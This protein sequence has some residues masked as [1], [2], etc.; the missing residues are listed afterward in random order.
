MPL[1]VI[2][3]FHLDFKVIFGEKRKKRK[4]WKLSISSPYAVA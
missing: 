4:N 2:L 1:G 3:E